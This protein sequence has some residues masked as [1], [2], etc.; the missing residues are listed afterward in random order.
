MGA[1]P[2]GFKSEEMENYSMDYARI[3]AMNTVRIVS[4]YDNS[5][6][7]LGG[8]FCPQWEAD[9]IQETL[10]I[11]RKVPETAVSSW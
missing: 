6:L 4:P 8:V 2:K 10:N 7:L 3:S 5:L 1:K 11:S 9:T